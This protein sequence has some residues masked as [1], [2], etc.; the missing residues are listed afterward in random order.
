MNILTSYWKIDSLFTTGLPGKNLAELCS[1]SYWA[2]SSCMVEEWVWYFEG[3]FSFLVSPSHLFFSYWK[4]PYPCIFTTTIW[5]SLGESYLN[6]WFLLPA[7]S[8]SWTTMKCLKIRQSLW[9]LFSLQT[10]VCRLCT[11]IN[12]SWTFIHKLL[13]PIPRSQSCAIWFS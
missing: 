5:G 6:L 7:E 8:S 13:M 1:P 12:S 4:P 9:C 11:G 10:L 2:R 3:H